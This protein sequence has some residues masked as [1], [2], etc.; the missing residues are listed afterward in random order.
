MNRIAVALLIGTIGLTPA[1]GFAG[2]GGHE[3]GP[4][5]ELVVVEMA[6]TPEEHRALAKYYRAKAQE[7]RAGAE[8]HE[9]MG[10]AYTSGKL[11]QRSRMKRHCQNIS[12]K[13]ASLAQEY[14]A[15]AK[16]HD[17]E[18]KKTE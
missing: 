2:E 9:K 14:E 13:E 1:I 5:L 18:A 16:L 4:S 15:L 8:Q 10:R 3:N 17:E 7:E 12:E 11:T 6:N